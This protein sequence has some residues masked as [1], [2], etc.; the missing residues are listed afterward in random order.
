MFLLFFTAWVSFT[1]TSHIRD[2]PPAKAVVV[3]VRV[4]HIDGNRAHTTFPPTR[5]VVKEDHHLVDESPS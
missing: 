1:R 3:C 4:G 2:D 5:D